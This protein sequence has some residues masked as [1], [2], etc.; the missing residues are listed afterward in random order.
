MA[1]SNSS[2]QGIL[3]FLCSSVNHELL[4]GITEKVRII[5]EQKSKIQQRNVRRKAEKLGNGGTL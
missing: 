4:T 1:C 5:L 2:C 3:S